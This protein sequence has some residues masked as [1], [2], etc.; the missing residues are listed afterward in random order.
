MRDSGR[1]SRSRAQ[2]EALMNRY[3]KNSPIDA[4]INSI[5]AVD[6]RLDE[7]VAVQKLLGASVPD[8]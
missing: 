8:L 4:T 2:S 1:I 3:Y 5:L 6:I 7:E